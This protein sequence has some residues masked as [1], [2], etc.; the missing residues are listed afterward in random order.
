MVDFPNLQQIYEPFS[1]VLEKIPVFSQFFWPR[2]LPGLNFFSAAPPRGCISLN[3]S[4]E[5]KLVK[6]REAKPIHIERQFFWLN[7]LHHRVHR[8]NMLSAMSEHSK[9]GC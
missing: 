7:D 8:N 4:C 2:A 9:D 1:G 3:K 6:L 5:K